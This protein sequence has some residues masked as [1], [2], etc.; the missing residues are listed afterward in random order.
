M[1]SDR[2]EHLSH[3]IASNVYLCYGTNMD[4]D[5]GYLEKLKKIATEGGFAEKGTLEE[6]QLGKAAKELRKLAHEIEMIR[7]LLII[8]SLQTA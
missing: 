6:M 7:E 4:A 3:M 5:Y 8:N 2:I 1:K